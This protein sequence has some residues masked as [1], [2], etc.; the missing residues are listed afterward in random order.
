ML[1]IGKG[2][3]FFFSTFFVLLI[4]F[5][6]LGIGVLGSHD[7]AKL[8]KRQEAHQQSAVTTTDHDEKLMK[9]KIMSFT[10][11][12]PSTRLEKVPSIYLT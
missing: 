8:E 4:P 1:D 11:S 6:H 5:D 9:L 7:I 10:D 2:I 3:F 12:K